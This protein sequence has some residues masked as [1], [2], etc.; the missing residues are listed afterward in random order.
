MTAQRTA[1]LRLEFANNH[2]VALASVVHSLLLQTLLPYSRYHSCL[3]MVLTAR[4]LP[5]VMKAPEDSV[6]LAG[7]EELRERY[8]DDVPGNP[9]DIFEWCLVRSQD[10]LLALLAYTA[11]QSIDA[12]KDKLD[13]RKHER[14]HSEALATAL[15]LDMT[16][17]FEATAKSYFNHL[18]RDGIAAAIREA[19]GPEFGNDLGRMKKTEAAAHAEDQVKGSGWLPSPIRPTQL[20]ATPSL[21]PLETQSFAGLEAA[22]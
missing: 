21:Q 18:T 12:V 6:A 20:L 15:K 11:A 7:L 3:D 17:Y 4:N 19:K 22:E 8:S 10:E 16:T 1:A 2:H 5:A 9:A 13:Y 14:V